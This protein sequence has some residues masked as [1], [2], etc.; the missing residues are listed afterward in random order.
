[1]AVEIKIFPFNTGSTTVSMD[2]FIPFV[3]ESSV[4]RYRDRR[5]VS[6]LFARCRCGPKAR[7]I[8]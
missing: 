6:P 7:A 5:F 2:V 3:R 4:S 8:L 1:M